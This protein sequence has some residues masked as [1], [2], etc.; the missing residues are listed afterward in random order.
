MNQIASPDHAV[1]S[2]YKA[3]AGRGVPGFTLIEMLV[4]LSILGIIG[5]VGVSSY[6]RESRVAAVRQAAIEMQSDLETLRSSTIRYNGDSKFVL[7]TGGKGYTLTIASNP[8]ARTVTRTFS[9]GVT[10]ATTANN[11]T[12]KA[13][14]STIDAADRSYELSF[15]SISYYVKVIG[16]T[17]KAVLSATP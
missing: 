9:N 12:Y 7:A 15:D 10:A 17:G 16:V 1:R 14:L 4:V 2:R 11:V 13:P 8:T 5:A 6:I 3:G